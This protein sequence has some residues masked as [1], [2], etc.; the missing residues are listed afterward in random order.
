MSLFVA[1]RPDAGAIEDL[2]HVIESVRRLPV[3]EGLR[4]QPPAQWHV[5]LAFLGDPDDDTAEEVAERL[6]DLDG[7]PPVHGLSLAGAGCF[8]RQVVWMGLCDDDAL[9]GLRALQAAVPPSLRGSGAIVDRRPW[10]PHLTVARARHG[11]GRSAAAVLDGYRGPRWDVD[12]VLLV[13]STGGPHPDH[14][15]TASVRLT[16]SPAP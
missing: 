11:D 3:A 8:G 4:W 14:R 12:E 15:V 16:G 9:A 1:V 13:R 10:R 5:T 2:Q 6:T 7:R